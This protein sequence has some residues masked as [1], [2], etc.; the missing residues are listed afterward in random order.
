VDKQVVALLVKKEPKTRER[1]YPDIYNHTA[2]LVKDKPGVDGYAVFW[3][4]KYYKAK[5]GYEQSR[6]PEWRSG[7][8]RIDIKHF[9]EAG[10]SDWTRESTMGAAGFY[11]KYYARA[12]TNP[13]S[14]WLIKKK[15]P[16]ELLD[17][18]K[19]QKLTRQLAK[20]DR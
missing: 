16:Q 19:C 10:Y 4:N 9:D 18:L 7:N 8:T 5:P 15:M 12:D 1:G 14:Q 13:N 2:V 17:D 6:G 11:R 3:L 20:G